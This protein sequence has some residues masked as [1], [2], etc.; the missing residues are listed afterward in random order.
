VTGDHDHDAIAVLGAVAIGAWWGTGANDGWVSFGAVAGAVIAVVVAVRTAAGSTVRAVAVVAAIALTLGGGASFLAWRAVEGL[1]TS[2]ARDERIGARLEASV[3]L[4]SDP[5]R[6]RFSS[7][8]VARITRVR[9]AGTQTSPH[10][11]NRRVLLTASGDAA[12]RVGLLDAGDT[13]TV[14]GALRPLRPVERRYQWQHCSARFVV[15]DVIALQGPTSLLGRTS[16]MMRGVVLA[17]SASLGPGARG[18]V[19]G[20][21]LGDTREIAPATSEQF[22]RAGLSHLLAVSGANVAFVLALVAPA[23]QR[24][25]LRGRFIGASTTLIIFGAMTRWQPSVLRAVAMA[26]VTLF[27]AWLGRPVSGLRIFSLAVTALFLADP[28]LIRSVGFALSCGACL[29]ILAFSRPLAAR[30]PGPRWLRDALSVTAAAQCGVA[31]VLLPVFG[32]IPLIALPANLA[33]AP[34]VG[35]LTMAGLA[36]STIASALQH[37]APPLATIVQTPASVLAR[38]L[39]TL[40]SVAAR[41]PLALTPARL[42]A[43]VAIS[44]AAGSAVVAAGGRR[45][46][47]AVRSPRYEAPPRDAT[48]RRHQ[49]GDR[50]GHLEPHA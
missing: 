8:S 4:T 12:S 24:L 6:F 2:I 45:H 18:I 22:R 29:G 28:F 48:N 26:L 47:P 13:I 19:R 30:I 17:G 38:T 3:T 15:S 20:F 25:S 21:V 34:L 5:V 49:P 39:A 36:G 46:N 23:L 16:A 31:P 44:A 27:G 43:V 11:V 41:Q 35:P 40:A 32:S 7:S 42:A 9:P 50:D 1:H 14:F 10:R 37:V 33:A